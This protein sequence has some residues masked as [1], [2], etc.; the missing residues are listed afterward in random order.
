VEPHTSAPW[1]RE[2]NENILILSNLLLEG[3]V[4]E[5][6]E[7]AGEL[8][9]DLRLQARLLCDEFGQALEITAAA[10]VDGLVALSVEPLDGWEARDAVVLAQRLV[11]VSVDT[12]DCDLV[13]SV[14]EDSRELLVDGCEIL[15]VAT[16]WGEELYKCRLAGLENDIAKGGGCEGLD[17]RGGGES[18]QQRDCGGYYLLEQHGVVSQRLE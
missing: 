17:C 6:H 8:A 15:A 11:L 1:R 5:V 9:L 7:L 13:R 18:G 14:L 10:V 4:V 2:G 16:P 12:C 3:L